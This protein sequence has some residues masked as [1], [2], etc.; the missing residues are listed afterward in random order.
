[1]PFWEIRL[2]GSPAMFSPLNR[3]RPEVGRITPVRQLKNVL[4]P[5]PFGPMMARISPRSTAKS[6][7]LRAVKPPKRTV[8]ASVRRMGAG[9]A[10][11]L[12]E[13]RD[14]GE[15]A[16]V[17]WG[18][19]EVLCWRRPGPFAGRGASTDSLGCGSGECARRRRHRL[20][21]RNDV[22]DV[23]LAVLDVEDELA[24]EGLVVFLAQQLVA[25]RE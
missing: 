23:V 1:M 10:L 15:G 2:E 19:R 11:P 20:L 12:A 24:Q 16:A 13:E 5:A 17:T 25:L 6:T 18:R 3:I 4:L 8:S 22:H 14:W 9:V 21:L 7:P